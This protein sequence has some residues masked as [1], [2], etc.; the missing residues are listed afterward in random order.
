M[1]PSLTSLVLLDRR[2]PKLLLVQPYFALSLAP[3]RLPMSG[4]ERSYTGTLQLVTLVVLV[5][6][7]H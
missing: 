7:G 5:P 1:I 4:E 2:D 3:L 6:Y